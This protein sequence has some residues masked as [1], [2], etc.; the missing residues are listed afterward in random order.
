MNEDRRIDT[1]YMDI[2]YRLQSAV[3]IALKKK[4]HHVSLV[5]LGFPS[6]RAL[7][8]PSSETIMK[9][10]ELIRL[11]LV[12]LRSRNP[13]VYTSKIE[14]WPGVACGGAAVRCIHCCDSRICVLYSLLELSQKNLLEIDCS[15]Y[16]HTFCTV[17]KDS[18]RKKI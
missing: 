16:L 1:D 4:S 6:Q 2:D 7:L 17:Q 5:D 18:V 9:N 11:P 13:E 3:A 14:L 15:S 10:V 8:S 12:E